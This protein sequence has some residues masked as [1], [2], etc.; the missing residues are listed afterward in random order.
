MY[1]FILLFGKS[2][3]FLNIPQVQVPFSESGTVVQ[4]TWGL[5]L[6]MLLLVVKNVTKK[7]T[8][9]QKKVDKKKVIL[10]PNDSGFKSHVNSKSLK[11]QERCQAY[12]KS[13]SR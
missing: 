1:F 12:N 9:C 4:I 8:L 3:T 6:Q 13:D 2:G 7:I 10:A 11:L 5:E